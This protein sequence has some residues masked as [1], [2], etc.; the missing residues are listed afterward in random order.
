MITKLGPKLILRRV[1]DAS[2]LAG[3]FRFG[4]QPEACAIRAPVM[5]GR[6]SNRRYSQADAS[7][8]DR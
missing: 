5:R 6:E 7:S 3:S 2:G 4:L 8:A 1:S